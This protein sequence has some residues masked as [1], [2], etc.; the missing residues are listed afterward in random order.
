MQEAKAVDLFADVIGDSFIL[1]VA[2]ALILYEYLR[3]K[4]KVDPN[5]EKISNMEEKVK[6]LLEKDQER[7]EEKNRQQQRVETLEQAMEEMR[8]ATAK[9]RGLLPLL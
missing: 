7:E 2:I 5:I 3:S 8:R 4:G 6:Q 9:K 1:G